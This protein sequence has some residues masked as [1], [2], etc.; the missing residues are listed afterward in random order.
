MK[1]NH[2][3]DWFAYETEYGAPPLD[4]SASIS[5]LGLPEGARAAAIASLEQADRYPDPQ[6]RA[7]RA[8]LAEHHGVPADRI[9]CGAGA[10]DL[11]YRL[12][13]SLR[14]RHALIPIP[15][16]TEY[17]RALREAD[18]MIRHFPL[19]ESED[20][21]LPDSF[22]D[23]I[24]PGTELVF[25]CQPN[26]PTGTI[27]DLAL[28]QHILQR[29][30]DIGA[31]MVVDECFLDLAD[32]PEAYTLI[33]ALADFTNLVIL[34][35]FTKTYAMAGLRLGY[36][37]CGDAVLAQRLDAQGQPW[38]V[39][40]P[41]DAAG[42]AALQD[43]DYLL[44]LRELI[45]HERPRM[46]HALTDMGYRVL[47]GSA[48]FLLFYSADKALGVKLRERGILIRDCSDFSGLKAG[49]YRI[50][51]RTAEENDALLWAL[52]EV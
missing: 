44:R 12:V 42:R 31:V 40:S 36:A 35:A 24:E 15:T 45:Q 47:H 51:I 22:P 16:F 7:L 13:H 8:A 26:N 9:V 33:N 34:K 20:F 37:L 50:A 6:C 5:P 46:E 43:K 1:Q 19:S 11:I 39:S 23:A 52:R 48:N 2:G 28:M 3:G 14:P 17:E 30:A 38:A 32:A 10:A 21:K 18:C 25:L 29:C 27:A 49:W 4:F 41:A